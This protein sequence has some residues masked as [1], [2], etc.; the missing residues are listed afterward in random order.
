[1]S[2][3]CQQDSGGKRAE[4]YVGPNGDD[5]WSG[6]CPE[7]NAATCDGERFWCARLPEV[8]SAR[9]D[10]RMLIVN[11]RFCERARLPE[12]G[13]LYQGFARPAPMR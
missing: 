6:R 2:D 4:F 5:A 9:W 7:P 13:T 10:F 3:C 1:M 11:D 12:T 8:A